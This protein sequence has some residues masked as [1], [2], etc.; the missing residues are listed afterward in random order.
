MV[1]IGAQLATADLSAFYFDVIKDRL[2]CDKPDSHRRRAAQVQ[3]V[4]LPDDAIELLRVVDSDPRPLCS[5]DGA[6]ARPRYIDERP[7]ADCTFRG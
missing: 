2:Y 4:S 1:L 7:R 5:S 6:A 3:A